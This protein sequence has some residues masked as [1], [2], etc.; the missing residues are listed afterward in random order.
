MCYRHFTRFFVVF[1]TNIP[2]IRTLRQVLTTFGLQRLSSTQ[3]V[4]LRWRKTRLFCT[5]RPPIQK[6][7]T[8]TVKSFHGH[9]LLF[10]VTCLSH[11]SPHY[12]WKLS[13]WPPPPHPINILAACV[14]G[15]IL[16]GKGLFSARESLMAR[17]LKRMH[18]ERMI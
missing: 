15:E 5:H 10:I 4:W 13:V 1:N 14:F 2:R 6:E 17:V 18:T 16:S 8:G 9:A 12:R 11:V 3:N 7:K